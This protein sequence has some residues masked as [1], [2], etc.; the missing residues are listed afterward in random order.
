[1]CHCLFKGLCKSV[2]KW[3]L[4]PRGHEWLPGVA[5]PGEID[6]AQYD[7]PKRMTL[8]S[9]IPWV[10]WLAEVWYFGEISTHILTNDSPGYDTPGRLTLRSM[11]PPGRLT[12]RSII[13]RG[14]WLIPWGDSWKFENLSK[15]L[16]NIEN[17]LTYWSMVSDQAWLKW[18]KKLE[19]ENLVG[20]SL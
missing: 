17:I 16:T 2:E 1:M 5:Y 8:C 13:P 20:L 19:V 4:T 14:D 7:T 3:L 12:L 11:I 10:D 6:S 15:N 18:W 9:M